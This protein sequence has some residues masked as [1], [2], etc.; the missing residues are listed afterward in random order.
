MFT[1]VIVSVFDTVLTSECDL[2]Q[3][4]HSS[5]TPLPGGQQK[6]FPFFLFA[7]VLITKFKAMKSQW[8]TAI[9][10]SGAYENLCNVNIIWNQ[11]HIS[12]FNQY[13]WLAWTCFLIN[14]Y[15]INPV[16]Y[17]KV[18]LHTYLGQQ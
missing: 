7:L 8:T 10:P 13:I 15:N 5:W 17:S 14:L 11:S 18:L 3:F 4:D 16:M 9:G 1:I 12:I 2:I 6:Y